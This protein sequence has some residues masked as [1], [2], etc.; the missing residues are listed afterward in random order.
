MAEQLATMRV[1]YVRTD[2]LDVG[3]LAP[4]WHEQLARWLDE[5][6]GTAEAKA[7]KGK[8]GVANAR[9][10]YQVYQE[11][12]STERWAVLAEAGALP[13]RPLLQRVPA[14]VRAVQDDLSRSRPRPRLGSS[15]GLALGSRR[16]RRHCVGRGD[17]RHGPPARRALARAARGVD[18]DRADLAGRRHDPLLRGR[19][20]TGGAVVAGG[21]RTAHSYSRAMAQVDI[22]YCPV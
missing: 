3:D 10:A 11:Q 5:A 6:I 22:Y 13:Q 17:R 16:R 7:L 14:A 19:P 20:E 9:L 15:R 12:F 2:E 4:T 21:I 1:D 8:A 18:L